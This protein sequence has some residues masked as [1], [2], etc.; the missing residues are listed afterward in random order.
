MRLAGRDR[1][2]DALED[3]AAVL[4]ARVEVFDFEHL[5]YLHSAGIKPNF[6]N[7]G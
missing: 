5:D 2:I 3:V 1:E 6:A 4:E 7:I